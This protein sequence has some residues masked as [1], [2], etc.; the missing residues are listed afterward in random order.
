MKSLRQQLR[1]PYP[2]LTL[3][4]ALQRDVFIAVFLA[5]FL[6]IFTPFGLHIY[7]PDRVH[8]ILGFGAVS[9]ITMALT[10]ILGYSLVKVV[11]QETSWTV[12]HQLFWGLW[13]LLILGFTNLLF[14]V[15][16]GGL[17]FS[18]DG[19]GEM[20]AQVLLSA[21]LP[22]TVYILL[23]QNYLLRINQKNA[24]RVS[25]ALQSMAGPSEKLLVF[26][27]DSD[28][29]QFQVNANHLLYM[30]SE[31]NYVQFVWENDKDIRKT[32][33]RS[34]LGRVEEVLVT[35]PDFFRCH[36]AF[37]VNLKKLKSVEGNSQG[38][39]LVLSQVEETLP[40]ARSRSA[41]LRQVVQSLNQNVS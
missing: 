22:L 21:I 11:F 12:K 19:F 29:G 36:R 20:E 41:A 16:I 1:E 15:A 26:K 24:S 5:L 39:R 27:A 23:R 32:L 2:L 38:Y 6:V 37:I 9:L 31:D 30:S 10:D 4:E 7:W 3:S 13:H 35:H 17:P 33:L 14:A 8:Y 18:W 25:H 34:T 28:R 40:V